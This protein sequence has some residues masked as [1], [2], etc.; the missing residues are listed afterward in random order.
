MNNFEERLTER[1]EQ[2]KN[3]PTGTTTE[4]MIGFAAGARWVIE[5]MKKEVNRCG[6]CDELV[7]WQ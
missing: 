1:L 4:E 5:E 7:I 6:A 2:L 3:Q